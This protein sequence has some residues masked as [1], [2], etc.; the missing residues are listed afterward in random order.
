MDADTPSKE[1]LL[2]SKKTAFVIS[3]RNHGYPELADLALREDVTP[4]Q[5]QEE[6]NTRISENEDF[7]ALRSL[8]EAATRMQW[9]ADDL[10]K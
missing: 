2:A 4:E 1:D 8:I 9:L 10:D 5:L 3:A 6:V 7:E